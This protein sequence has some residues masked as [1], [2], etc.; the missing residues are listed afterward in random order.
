MWVPR[1]YQSMALSKVTHPLTLAR[2]LRD[3]A[4]IL[5]RTALLRE[6]DPEAKDRLLKRATDKDELAA[7]FEKFYERIMRSPHYEENAAAWTDWPER[8]PQE[9][10]AG[11]RRIIAETQAFIAKAEPVVE[12]F[13]GEC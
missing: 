13:K 9:V 12:S 6:D 10:M 5:G 3:E 2:R 8:P 4:T 7:S 11:L 1:H